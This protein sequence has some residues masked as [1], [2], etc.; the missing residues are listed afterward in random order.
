[1][2]GQHVALVN[3]TQTKIASF[4]QES[5][6][7]FHAFDNSQGLILN[8]K[9][10]VLAASV[11]T[12]IVA[13][14]KRKGTL[15]QYEG[16]II[17]GADF[18]VPTHYLRKSK[19]GQE[20]RVIFYSG[21]HFIDHQFSAG[22][23]DND[24]RNFYPGHHYLNSPLKN[25]LVK[26]CDAFIEIPIYTPNPPLIQAKK[27]HYHQPIPVAV[28]LV[29]IKQDQVDS[30]YCFPNNNYDY[31]SILVKKNITS[32]PYSPHILPHFQLKKSLHA[33]LTPA[34]I[35]TLNHD[36]TEPQ[37]QHLQERRFH[38]L[39]DKLAEGTTA[40]SWEKATSATARLAKQVL[41]KKRVRTATMLKLPF[42]EIV[43]YH[44]QQAYDAAAE[45]LIQH[46][47]NNGLKSEILSI[48]NRLYF[49]QIIIHLIENEE[50]LSMRGF[51]YLNQLYPAMEQALN[52]IYEQKEKL[53]LQDLFQSARTFS[54]LTADHIYYFAKE[55]HNI[56]NSDE[57]MDRFGQFIELIKA[58]QEK[59]RAAAFNPEQAW[60]FL[61]LIRAA[62]QT[63]TTV[64][65][66]GRIEDVEEDAL[67]LYNGRAFYLQLLETIPPGQLAIDYLRR[68]LSQVGSLP[69][70]E[71]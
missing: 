8:P 66:D 9:G 25:E 60:E 24:Y 57:F 28:L 21:C 67:Y 53:T 7:L 69:S 42:E 59:H 46:A 10:T 18:Q 65:Y 56:F 38:K 50:E 41:L 62:D 47:L 3:A 16:D 13:T 61:Q 37:E 43:D 20:K 52:E 27:Y 12:S 2:P 70:A 1:T 48:R 44:F 19:R 51:K 5:I 6:V 32:K 14:A 15:I 31:R 34:V 55:D 29:I 71:P 40:K 17:Q 33:L 35:H 45:Y 49:I 22:L 39:F 68:E 4:A 36:Q 54:Y 30:V 23:S 64:E 26:G 11:T 58:L 63:R